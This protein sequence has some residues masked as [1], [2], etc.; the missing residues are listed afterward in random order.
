MGDDVSSASPPELELRENSR[1]RIKRR[2]GEGS[3]GSV[4][5][6]YDRERDADVA[7]KTLRRV[8]ASSIYRFKRE[9]RALSDMVHPN[10]VVL[11][12]LFHEGDLWYF[13]ME[14]VEG[15]DFLTH[16]LSNNFRTM[17]APRPTP[18]GEESARGTRDSGELQARGL[19]ML[20]PTPLHDEE[21]LRG[22]L[23]QITHGLLAI[24]ASGK[25]HRD[26]K[27]DNVLVTPQGQAKVLDF[28]IVIERAGEIHST[29][30][31]G[32]MG[33]PAYMSPEQA[34]GRPVAEATDWYALG[35]MIY[36]ALTGNVP[37]DGTYLE[38]MQQK[39]QVD[40]P[41]PSALV[42]GVPED[43]EE[44]CMRLLQ[45]HPS[46]RPD[47]LSILRSIERRR[48]PS[49]RP[50]TS[51][52]PAEPDAPFVGRGEELSALR[53]HLGET[54]RGKP[55]LSFIHGPS[56][57][58]K[59]TLVERFAHEQRIAERAVVLKGRCY[60]RE[61]V[62][63]KAFDS[64]IDS[65]SRYLRRLPSVE[66]AETLPRD[67]Q[68]LAHLFPVLKRGEV[69]SGAKRRGGLP[70]DRNELRRR[71]FGA[72]KELFC[73]IADRMPLV[74]FVD[75]LQW[76]DVDSARLMAELVRGD[77]A[78]A[79]HLVLTYRSAEVQTSPCLQALFEETRENDDAEIHDIS[80]GPLSPDESRELA[81]QLLGAD[82]PA[83]VDGIG[84]E[85]QG[86]PHL[87][88]ELARHLLI[89]AEEGTASPETQ[90]GLVSFERAVLK[91]VDELGQGAR[92]LLELVSVSGRPVPEESLA[93]VSSFDIDLQQALVELRGAKLIRGVGTHQRRA[94]A[95]YHD[96]IREAVVG[97][98][99]EERLELWHRRL[100]STLEASGSDDLEA[101]VEHLLGANDR[102]RAQI[103]AIRAA[104]QAAEALA[105]EKAARLFAVAV[106]NE[107]DEAWGHELLVKWADSLVNAGHGRQ[108]AA[109]YFDA[110]RTADEEE[111]A[112]LRRKAG[113][114]LLCTGHE[115]QALDL[116]ADT[117]R[118]LELRVPSDLTDGAQDLAAL[119]ARLAERG[120][121][122]TPRDAE[123]VGEA[124]L[125]RLD[126]LW[127]LTVGVMLIQVDRAM[128]LMVRYLLEARDVGEP[129]RVA[130]GMAMVHAAVDAPL[131]ALEGK[132]T[133][134]ALEIIEGMEVAGESEV[135]ARL[136]FA[137]GLDALRVGELKPALRELG[138]AEEL[139]RTRCAG[140]A[141]EMRFC[142]MVVARL[143][144]GFVQVEHFRRVDEWA[145]EAEEHEDLLAATRL[146]LLTIT[147]LLAAGEAERAE[148]AARQAM[149]RWG[150]ERADMSYML[151]VDA[152]TKLGLYMSESETCA[153]Q[154]ERFETF[155]ASSLA[156]VP[157]LRAE[158]LLLR[159]RAA[160]CAASAQER[161]D[162]H[163]TLLGA[164]EEDAEALS[165]LGLGC[166][167][168][169]VRLLRA[170][171]AIRRGDRD[172]ALALCEAVL[173]DP[174]EHPDEVFT[175]AAAQRQKG[176]LLGGEE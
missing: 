119:R 162:R 23:E 126:L 104:T 30:E 155:F 92:T 116:L 54:D 83:A 65:L 14:Y 36:E 39:Q 64:L 51:S 32:V 43:L 138:R 53:R 71:A 7:L 31:V 151:W 17:P 102:K 68:A 139:L 25:L 136:A 166:Y 29:L 89:G 87:V 149:A 55:V 173:A 41:P 143:L 158:A 49:I 22:V 115:Q 122:F 75:D 44:L 113:L 8:D 101:I 79:M 46:A 86:S 11:H 121:E 98:M 90:R 37:F 18:E 167:D 133:M 20:F 107:D 159:A 141:P 137:R 127:S 118:E 153:V 57:I 152:T 62:P 170:Q 88:A 99:P 150:A 10:L 108:A 123:A 61:A 91:R 60:E 74:L 1:F 58:G 168:S 112:V 59:T 9:F 175:V 3:M 52:V 13:T 42:S 34:A 66:A 73:R 164:A 109:V 117:L 78:P 169:H 56:G 94:V 81:R 145:R 131:S 125:D 154:R 82:V 26:L 132:E 21:R 6:A 70:P 80:L 165:A 47:G 96:R 67:I 40:P 38:V 148:R 48:P 77:D 128:P 105:F 172:T 124:A 176:E 134:G 100:A 50:P 120:L 157:L 24:H 15:E 130:C 2:L 12:D 161:E 156:A 63:F 174:S 72:L 97:A 114:Q 69:V 84:S 142:R 28:G 85:S 45:R 93:L 144:M 146:R 111:A 103:Y 19:E 27:S 147:P 140:A 129:V 16:V 135:R 95:I 106:E 160:L 163:G 76:G 4:Y 5:L 110:A 35:V 33:T 171:V